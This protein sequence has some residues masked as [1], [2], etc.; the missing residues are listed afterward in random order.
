MKSVSSSGMPS[1]CSDWVFIRPVAFFTW[2][3]RFII[4]KQ[5]RRTMTVSLKM[6]CGLWPK[7]IPIG[8]FGWC[9]T[10][11]EWITTPGITNVFTEFIRTWNW[12]CAENT[13]EDFRRALKSLYCSHWCPTSHGRWI[14]CTTVC[15]LV[16]LF[17]RLMWLMILIGKRWIL[18]LILH[19]IAVA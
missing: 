7:C 17:V 9:F 6:N 1:M 19:S 11:Y 16:R 14:L 13:N 10:I 4:T 3:R 15:S 12:I 8:A 18:R 2:V 5:S